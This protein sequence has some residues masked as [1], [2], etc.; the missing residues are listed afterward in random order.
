MNTYHAAPWS[1]SYDRRYRRSHHKRT[2]QR[3][4]EDW[5]WED[6]LDDKGSWTWEE[7]LAGR[8]RLPWEQVEA[9]RESR[10]R[11]KHERQPPNVFWGWHTGR[12]AESG[13][14]PEPT[15]HAYRG[16]RMTGQAPCYP[17]RSVQ[18]PSSGRARVGMQPGSTFLASGA[19]LRHRLSCASSTHGVPGLPA[20]PSAACSNSLHLS[21]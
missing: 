13:C 7:I 16:E 1:P 10:Q 5:T 4:Q 21:G 19:S 11:R 6:I 17:V 9:A 2:K 3:G 15:P 8:D 12:L 14:R 18:A 20:K